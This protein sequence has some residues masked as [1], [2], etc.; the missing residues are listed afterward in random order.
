MTDRGI[1]T[2][3]ENE[4]TVILQ[5]T[6]LIDDKMIDTGNLFVETFKKQGEKKEWKRARSYIEAGVPNRNLD[7]LHI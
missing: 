7:K 1:F 6:I 4:M 5:A 2:L 3:R